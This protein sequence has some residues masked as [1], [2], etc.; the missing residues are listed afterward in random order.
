MGEQSAGSI[1]VVAS[2]RNVWKVKIEEV[3]SK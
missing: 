1:G 2:S 3:E